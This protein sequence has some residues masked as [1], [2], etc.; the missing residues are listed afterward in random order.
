MPS[1]QNITYRLWLASGA[2]S[3]GCRGLRITSATN[4]LCSQRGIGVGSGMPGTT[5]NGKNWVSN[6]RW[7]RSAI[8]RLTTRHHPP[9]HPS[10]QPGRPHYPLACRKTRHHPF[11]LPTRLDPM[12]LCVCPTRPPTPAIKIRLFLPRT[13]AC[14]L[15]VSRTATILAQRACSC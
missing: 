15:P 7:G 10:S 5:K 14:S 2:E 11:P 8:P 3:A 6:C 13:T 9:S 12:V 1:R 4:L